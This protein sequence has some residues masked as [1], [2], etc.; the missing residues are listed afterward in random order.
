MS[1]PAAS[2]AEVVD[3]SP[4]DEILKTED[5]LGDETPF[6]RVGYALTPIAE[7]FVC[8]DL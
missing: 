2:H 4:L 1:I 8:V 6:W 3:F 7:V 5:C